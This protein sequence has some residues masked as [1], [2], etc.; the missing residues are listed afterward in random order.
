MEGKGTDSQN[1]VVLANAAIALHH[2][3]K[4]GTY[5]DCLA[6]AKES[7]FNGKAIN[8]LQLLVDG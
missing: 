5:Q 7:L 8:S 3:N 2:I 6:L 4:F 1:S